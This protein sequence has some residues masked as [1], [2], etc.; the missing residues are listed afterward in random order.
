MESEL[1]CPAFS[2]PG[3]IWLL[4]DRK[5]NLVCTD[6]PYFV[7][8]QNKSGTIANNNL[9]DKEAYEFL[10]KVFTNFKNAMAKDASIYEFYAI[11]LLK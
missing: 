4:G 1:K 2:K 3:D 9:G 6:A 7:N 11:V 8:L 10:M 5:V